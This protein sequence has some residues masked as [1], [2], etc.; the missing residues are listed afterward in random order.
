MRPAR[1]SPFRVVL[2]AL[3]LAALAPRAATADRGALTL[4]LGPAL[5]LVRSAPSLGSGPEL[6][7]TMGGGLVGVRYGLRNDLELTA[8]AFWEAPATFYHSATSASVSGQTLEGTLGETAG[9][10][11]LLLGARLVRGFLWRYSL[12]VE[13]GWSHQSFS[14]RDLVYPSTPGSSTTFDQRFG[15]MERDAL[16]VAPL[17]GLE[18]QLGDHW[19]IAA[20]PRLEFL[21]GGVG[22]LS[23]VLPVTVGYSWYLL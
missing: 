21:V 5:T 19:S 11:G 3:L 15:G 8:A 13:V 16:V 18:W 7:G 17:A 10:H 12:G 22:R 20:T 9:R 6:T 23:F 14:G 2:P 4:E 1:H